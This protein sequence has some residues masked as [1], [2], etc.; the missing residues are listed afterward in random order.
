MKTNYFVSSVTRPGWLLRPGG[1]QVM[2]EEENEQ[3][4]EQRSRG[5]GG[6]RHN[7]IPWA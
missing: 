3:N 7:Y 1:Y 6:G 4:R 2:Y 5:T